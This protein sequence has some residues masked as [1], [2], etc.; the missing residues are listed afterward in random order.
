MRTRLLGRSSQRSCRDCSNRVLGVISGL[1]AVRAIGSHSSAKRRS[2]SWSRTGPLRCFGS[3]L[4]IGLLQIDSQSAL[5]IGVG[6][7]V[8]AVA[9]TLGIVGPERRLRRR[10]R[11][12]APSQR[13]CG[14]GHER[15]TD[16]T[17]TPRRSA[18][19]MAARQKLGAG[20]LR[21]HRDRQLRRLVRSHCHLEDEIRAASV[22]VCERT[23]AVIAEQQK[24]IS[25]LKMLRAGLT[26]A[27]PT[28]YAMPPSGSEAPHIGVNDAAAS[29]FSDW[30]R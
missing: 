7:G 24:F 25:L 4:R 12:G 11:T 2:P 21:N 29:T 26:R 17:E 27:R 5:H 28:V 13:E 20:P 18:V 1:L 9:L 10:L 23:K 8:G 22:I 19:A 16:H 30:R 14:C 6:A 15:D 3:P